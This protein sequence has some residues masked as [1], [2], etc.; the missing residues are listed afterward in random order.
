GKPKC[1]GAAKVG[2]N[3]EAR[4]GLVARSSRGFTATL[5]LLSTPSQPV[6]RSICRT[7]SREFLSTIPCDNRCR[8]ARKLSLSRWQGTQDRMT[9]GGRPTP[10]E[11]ALHCAKITTRIL[12]RDPPTAHAS[13]T[14]AKGPLD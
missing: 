1:S 7:R 14:S 5:P 12:G 9:S 2:F 11:T 10:R 8:R 4:Q 6:D 3:R 13:D